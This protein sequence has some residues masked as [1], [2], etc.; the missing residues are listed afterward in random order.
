M[1]APRTRGLARR[2]RDQAGA[3]HPRRGAGY[4]GGMSST[5]P[6]NRKVLRDVAR[7]AMLERGLLPDFSPEALAEAA[8][9]PSAAARG[10]RGR[11]RPAR[12]A[13]GSIDNDD[14]RDLDQLTV[15]EPLRG[16]RG[17]DPGRRRR[18]RRA[19]RRRARRIDAHART[20]TTSVYTAAA[21]LPDAAGAA[22]DRPHLARTTARSG[23]RSWSRWR[24]APTAARCRL[25]RLPGAGAQPRQA[26]LRRRGR[27][28]RRHRPGA[29]SAIARG[30]RAGGATLRLQDRVAQRMRG[31]RGTSTARSSL[32]TI[33]ARPVFDGDVLADLGRGRENRAKELIE[34]FM[35]AANGV[36]ARYLGA[37]RLPVAAPRACARR[38]AGS[39]SSSWP[40]GYGET[41]PDRPDAGAL[42]AFLARRAPADPLRFPD[43]SLAVV[44]LLGSGE[45]VAGAAGRAGA[46][47]LRPRGAGLHPLHRAQPPL[48]RPRHAAPAEGR[49]G[50]GARRPTATTS[51]PSWRGTA[52]S[53]RTTPTRSSGRCAS[54]PRR[55]C[56]IGGSASGSTAS[57]PAPRPRAPGCASS[58]P[59]V[60][61]RVVRGFERPRRRRPGPRASWSDTDVERGFID[62]VRARE[63][64]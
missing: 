11:S 52:P 45:Y 47:A 38:S 16:R 34:D 41:L 26:R 55:C 14:S 4:L 3:L 2:F 48:P 12:P 62:F 54:P 24:S 6:G 22:L 59:P 1:R 33:E 8:A 35:I 19:G 42:E 63:G 40:P 10:R 23:W 39:A 43:L 49:A 46:R 60:E 36:T 30:A 53:R 64:T 51:W 20:N 9:S 56:S 57:S 18:R 25:G 31:A 58:Q 17:E 44:K 21:D 28:A 7:R 27:L 29:R 5:G 61:G 37:E 50:R 13:L 15:A 32:E